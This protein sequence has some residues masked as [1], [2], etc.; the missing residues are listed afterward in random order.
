MYKHIVAAVT[1]AVLLVATGATSQAAPGR[2]GGASAGPYYYQ[3]AG[4]P[5]G[6]R[7]YSYEP[8]YRSFSYEP[9]SVIVTTRATTSASARRPSYMDAGSK[10]LG[11][12]GK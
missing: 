6:Y 12:Y 9:G 3:T 8:G 2:C 5:T 10:A 11:R 7:S 1:V 4:A